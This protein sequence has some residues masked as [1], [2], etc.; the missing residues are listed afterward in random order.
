MALRK[1]KI[2][3]IATSS[4]TMHYALILVWQRHERARG[5]YNDISW[6]LCGIISIVILESGVFSC[7]D[8]CGTTAVKDARNSPRIR[9]TLF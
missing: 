6:T 5:T 4:E 9:D 1:A 3:K 8:I 7:L 2:W